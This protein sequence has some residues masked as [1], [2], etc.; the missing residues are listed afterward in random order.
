MTFPQRNDL[1][2][3]AEL[4]EVKRREPALPILSRLELTC[5]KAIWCAGAKTVLQVQQQLK[6][7]RPLAYTTV[8]TVLDRMVHKGALVRVKRGKAYQYEPAFS[9]EESRL[10][11]LA[12]L[13]D[14]YFEGSPE[15]LREFLNTTSMSH[16]VQSSTRQTTLESTEINVALL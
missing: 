5:M 10:K 15:K 6:P 1:E 13:I 9:Y 3:E 8:L 2:Q 7:R 4:P 11:A 14:F 12:E 16:E